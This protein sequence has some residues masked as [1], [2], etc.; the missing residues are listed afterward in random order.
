MESSRFHRCLLILCASLLISTSTQNPP[1]HHVAL[2]IFGDSL[3]DAGNNN[4]LKNAIGLANFWPYGETFF[5]HPTGRFS[6]GRLISDFIAEYLKLPLIPPY[7]QPGID[8]FTDGVNFASGGAGALVET[9]QG[10]EG[11]VIDL[12]TQVLYLKNVK[13]HIQQQKGDAE[14]RRLLSRA[15]Y[16]I[17]IGGNDYIAPSSVFE[18]FSKEEYVGMV[19]GNLTSVIKEI[20]KI[21]GRKFAFVGMGAFDC[22][23]N[24]R[25]LKQD[26]GG[27]DEEITA[28]AKLHNQV[29]PEILKELKSE[30]KDFK[31]SFFDFYST[32]SERI[33]NPSKY[34]FK[35]ANEACCG[36]GPF[37]GV[38]SSC[39]ISKDYKVCED[40]SEYLFFDSVHPTEK[41][42]KQLAKLI[43]RG[44]YNVSWPYNIKTLVDADLKHSFCN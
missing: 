18:S 24:M 11:R 23:P 36:S 1:Q 28:L 15:I 40:V 9:H 25:A 21:G 3:F 12:K 38:L 19:I 30:L 13:E 4:Y 22:S 10:N 41:A 7:L 27:C 33:N 14:T 6:D 29:L 39:G 34:G 35:V 8:H 20:Y 37:R 2:F 43:W 31:Y 5:K 26:E 42:Y 44:G 32:L 16:L 17:S